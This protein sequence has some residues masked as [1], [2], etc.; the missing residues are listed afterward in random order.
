MPLHYQKNTTTLLT[1]PGTNHIVFCVGDSEHNSQGEGWH[2][3]Y[4]LQCIV[5]YNSVLLEGVI[6]SIVC[7]V[8]VDQS[9]LFNNAFPNLGYLVNVHFSRCPLFIYLFLQL[10][11]YCESAETVRI[12]LIYIWLFAEFEFLRYILYGFLVFRVFLF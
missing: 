2:H 3:V 4:R 11:S 8:L 1:L 5:L 12:S 9:V 6:L 10:T 7:C